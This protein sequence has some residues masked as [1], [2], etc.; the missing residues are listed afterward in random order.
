MV[1]ISKVMIYGNIIFTGVNII[2]TGNR[3]FLG[4]QELSMVMF[5]GDGADGKLFVIATKEWGVF[6]WELFYLFGA[7]GSRDR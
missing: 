1:N 2:I 6:F 3:F 4:E 7:A 5:L